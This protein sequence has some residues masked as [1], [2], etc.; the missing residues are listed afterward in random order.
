MNLKEAM[1]RARETGKTQKVTEPLSP[2]EVTVKVS[3]T[4]RVDGDVLQAIKKEA[5][6]EGLPYQTKINSILTK[7]VNQK[8]ALELRVETVEQALV[9]LGWKKVKQKNKAVVGEAVAIVA[10]ASK[11]K[12]KGL[13]EL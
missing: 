1:K 7:H 12:N 11:R 2:D 4:L 6:A 5:A 13:V 10:P 9:K 3:V 8:D